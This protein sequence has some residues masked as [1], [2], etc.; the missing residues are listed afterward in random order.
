M[1][2]EIR[3]WR[4]KAGIN[5]SRAMKEFAVLSGAGK[6]RFFVDGDAF[7]RL[8]EEKSRIWY[9]TN[10][11]AAADPVIDP[12]IKNEN[13]IKVLRKKYHKLILKTHPDRGG[14]PEDFIRVLNAYRKKS[15]SLLK[16]I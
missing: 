7:I 4:R 1:K 13:D 6:E 10:Y 9:A 3:E 2:R 15:D 11:S 8:I 14:S 12:M 5:S 16:N